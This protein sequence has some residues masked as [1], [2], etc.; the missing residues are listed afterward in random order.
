MLERFACFAEMFPDLGFRSKSLDKIINLRIGMAPGRYATMAIFLSIAISLSVSLSISLL[1]FGFAGLFFSDFDSNPLFS[2]FSLFGF[3]F[4]IF[5]V[6][7]AFFLLLPRIEM[8]RRIAAMESEMPFFLR[9]TGM[10]LEM[11][12]P[13]QQALSIASED[14]GYERADLNMKDSGKW[15]CKSGDCDHSGRGNRSCIGKEIAFILVQEK[16]GISLAKSFS[17]FSSSTDSLIIKR[18]VSQL[19]NSY[20]IGSPGSELRRMGDDMLARE[21]HRIKE[22]SARMAMFGLLFMISSAIAPTFFLVY[23]ILGRTALNTDITDSQ[24][25][26]GMLV[27]FPLASILILLVSKA[28]VP[29]SAF[30]ERGGFD[31]RMIV[32]GILF[33]SGF[34]LFPEMQVPLI[35]AGVAA[36]ILLVYSSYSGERRLEDIENHLPDALFAISSLPASIKPERLFALIK[37]GN[38]GALSE[39]AQKTQRQLAMNVPLDK[40]LG[41]LSGRNGSVMLDRACAMLNHMIRTNCLDRMSALAEDMVVASQMRRERS[42]MMAM[43]KYTLLFGAILIPLI[44]RM[45]IGLLSGMQG[46][47]GGDSGDDMI[48]FALVIIPPYLV[49]Y[50]LIASSAIADAE[51]K[52]S[53]AAMYFALMSTLSLATFWFINL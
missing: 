37:E 52:R 23:A 14:A 1:G 28:M 17:S 29:E 38:H 42:Q 19:L 26:L 21:S 46:L 30:R 47:L 10:L 51:G 7:F 13:F 12:I 43:Q 22:H 5:A 48:A 15:G 32:P 44:F 8:K 4:L 34:V 6:V 33:V 49:I 41:D 3:C 25:A 20:A 50:A 9:S 35:V 40:A 31:A 36:S 2:I 27:V 18:A 53:V 16:E 39:E 24:I 45:T 11:K